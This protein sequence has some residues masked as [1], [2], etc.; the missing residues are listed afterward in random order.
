MKIEIII[1]ADY[2]KELNLI[3]NT[4]I[5]KD[6]ILNALIKFVGRDTVI[7]YETFPA[8]IDVAT[9]KLVNYNPYHPSL[10]NFVE[11]E[12]RIKDAGDWLFEK[13]VNYM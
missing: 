11:D 5:V 2:D 12:P 10:S 9:G 4:K 3:K 13:H 1:D 7:E 6:E 8:E